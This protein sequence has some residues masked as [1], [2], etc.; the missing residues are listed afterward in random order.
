[1][2]LLNS[3]HTSFSPAI[4]HILPNVD[5]SGF[6]YGDVW[7]QH[8]LSQSERDRLDD[9]VGQ[10]LIDQDVHD[11]LLFQRDP[12]LF[13]A[14]NLSDDTRRWCATLQASTLKE[15]AQAIIAAATPRY[16]R[17]ETAAV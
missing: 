16:E 3:Y 14:F 8:T 5:R 6:A 15:F 13:D 4:L 1:M 11:R 7:Q 17:L 2:S 12:S 10:A 9:L